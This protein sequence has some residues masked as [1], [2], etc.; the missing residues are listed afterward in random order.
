MKRSEWVKE[1][2]NDCQFIALAGHSIMC[3][4]GKTRNYCNFNICPR[5]ELEKKEE[6]RPKL[7]VIRG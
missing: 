3:D 2:Q 5:I 1:V 6:D 7:K 4:E